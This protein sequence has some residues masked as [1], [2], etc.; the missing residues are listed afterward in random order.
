MSFRVTFHHKAIDSIQTVSE[1]F[2]FARL[3][4]RL[5]VEDIAR[6]LQISPLYLEA[7]E[8][9]NYAKLPCLIYTRNF[10]KCYGNALGLNIQQLMKQFEHEWQLFEKHQQPLLNVEKKMSV[11]AKD[12]WRMPRWIRLASTAVFMIALV[13]YFGF[14]LYALRQPPEL[15]VYAPDEEVITDKQL[16][17][18]EGEAEAEV[19]LTINDQEVLSDSQGYF[20]ELVGLQPGM[21]IVEIKAKKKYSQEN[22]VYRKIM[23]E[24]RSA[25]S[26]AEDLEPEL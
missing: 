14:E 1:L 2:Q 8:Q 12:L 4:Q 24:D 18:I 9:G 11:D 23:V 16:I 20:K 3:E 26:A 10:V 5:D 6:D 13:S 19:V 22:T 25:F 15:A 17:Q 7:L 21:N